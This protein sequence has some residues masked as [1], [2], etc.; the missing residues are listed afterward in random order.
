MWIIQIVKSAEKELKKAPSEVRDSFDAWKNLIEQYGPS[1]IQ[2]MNGYWDH[3]LKGEWAGARSSLLNQKWR[4]IYVVEGSA[5]RILV[6][7]ITPHDYRR[8]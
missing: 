1:G 3:S 2:R 6:L 5:V 7:K 4:V 8:K